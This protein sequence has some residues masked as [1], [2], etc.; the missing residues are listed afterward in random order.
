MRSRADTSN[1]S[2]K[3]LYPTLLERKATYEERIYFPI[4][5]DLPQVTIAYDRLETDEDGELH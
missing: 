4:A 1:A 3:K 2:F 5:D